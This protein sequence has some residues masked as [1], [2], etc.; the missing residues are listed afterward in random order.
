MGLF[1]HILYFLKKIYGKNKWRKLKLQ[2][3]FTLT[4]WQL[5]LT[6]LFFFISS[7]SPRT[8][9]EFSASNALSFHSFNNWNCQCKYYA[10]M[11]GIKFFVVIQQHACLPVIEQGN[12]IK[13]R[14]FSWT[15]KNYFPFLWKWEREKLYV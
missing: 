9:D 10:F 3:G 14:I 15:I 8:S 11:L 5:T 12:V 1:C 7:F 4:S 6:F 2:N 13:K